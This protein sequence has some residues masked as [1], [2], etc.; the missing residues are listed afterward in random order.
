MTRYLVSLAQSSGPAPPGG[1]FGGM[2]IPILLI[3]GVLCLLSY[4]LK[5]AKKKHAMLSQLKN[6]GV[7][8]ESAAAAGPAL[9][10]ERK[11]HAMGIAD[12]ITKL[13]Q[14]HDSG[15]LSD[16][17]YETAKARVLGG[18]GAT[19]P[20]KVKEASERPAATAPKSEALGVMLVGVPA[21][22][23]M[24]IWF[25]VGNMNLFQNPGST[26]NLLGLLT[27]LGTAALAAGEASRLGMGSAT[28][29]NPK[30]KRREGPAHWFFG[31]LL[32]WILAYPFYLHRRR[33]YGVRSLLVGGVL[34]ALVFVGSW[35]GMNSAIESKVSHVRNIFNE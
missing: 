7:V 25:W 12:E 8:S 22:T 33:L 28:D 20:A 30:G 10:H 5:K 13:K 11:E 1:A 6:D 34:I 18:E 24:L 23:T 29:L 3:L 26:L 2:L 19:G 27:I 14:L 15:A 16:Q 32:L 4:I 17:E 31:L 35:F 9:S 21:A